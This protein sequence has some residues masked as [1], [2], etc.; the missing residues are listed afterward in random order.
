MQTLKK[1]AKKTAL[2]SRW[3]D[4]PANGKRLASLINQENSQ[5]INVVEGLPLISRLPGFVYGPLRNIGPYYIREQKAVS[6]I[7]IE[8]INEAPEILNFNFFGV[9]VKTADGQLVRYD[10]PSK[11]EM[12]SVSDVLPEPE[13][14]IKGDERNTVS[15]HSRRE[16]KPWWQITFPETPLFP[17]L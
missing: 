7:K 11:C 3:T 4:K 8:I 6:S 13:A 12:S 10:G 14:A 15:V 16:L 17:F 1:W 5:Q 9:W 2:L